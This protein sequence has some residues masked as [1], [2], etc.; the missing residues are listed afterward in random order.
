M[1]AV[2]VKRLPI[3]FSGEMV[4]AQR[5]GLKT[6]TRRTAGL[7]KANKHPDEWEYQGL[8][9]HGQHLFYPKSEE[10]LDGWDGLAR[11]PYG[12]AGDIL[13]LR[14]GYRSLIW[15]PGFLTVITYKADGETRQVLVPVDA[16]VQLPGGHPGIHLPQWASRKDLLNVSVRPERL[17]AISYTDAIAEGMDDNA[18]LNNYGTGS[19]AKDAF[20]ALWDRINAQRGAG[21]NKNFWVW[22]VEFRD[23]E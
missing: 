2:E 7:D 15:M 3:L 6:V 18:P 22:R 19:I 10:Y 11:C 9:V 1:E 17:H 21:W 5:K 13:W 20:A 4:T 8:N 12:K 16:H 14:E 23:I